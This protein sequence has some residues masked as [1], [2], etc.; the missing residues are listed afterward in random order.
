MAK[1]AVIFR[2]G[3]VVENYLDNRGRS[4]NFSTRLR[5]GKLADAW[6]SLGPETIVTAGVASNLLRRGPHSLNAIPYGKRQQGAQLPYLAHAL[7][8]SRIRTRTG[9]LIKSI[10]LRQ[11]VRQIRFFRTKRS[12]GV[13]LARSRR[14]SHIFQLE[15]AN[16]EGRL[17]AT[18]KA[19]CVCRQKISPAISAPS[20]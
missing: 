14:R 18:D 19:K 7:K 17:S 9:P 20:S 10:E 12:V 3:C 6:R 16:A 5:G 11:Y 1:Y 13:D 8:L 15:Q 2:A 4:Q